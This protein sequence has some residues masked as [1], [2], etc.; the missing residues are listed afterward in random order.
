MET[1]FAHVNRRS[2][3]TRAATLLAAGSSLAAPPLQADP[4]AELASFSVFDKADLAQLRGDARAVRGAPMN[5][6]RFLSVQT[7]WVAPGTPAQQLQALRQW[8][9]SRHSELRVHLHSGGSNFSRLAQAP[10]NAA[11]QWLVTATTSKSPDLQLSRAEAAKLPANG[12]GMS[13]PVA[14]FWVGV[15]SARSSIGPTGQPPYEHGGPTIKPGAEINGMLSQQGKIQ[16]QFSGLL[17]GRGDQFWELLEV[18]N[19]GVL[20]LGTSYQRS[21][22]GGTQQAGDVLYYASGGFYAA[23]TLHQMWPVQVEGKPATLIWRG[24]M[25]S[26]ASVGDLRGVERMGSESVMMRDISRAVR[27]FR[28]DSAGIR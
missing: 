14:D 7:V 2:F 19:K 23:I 1:N 12:S 27:L 20:V 8:N 21:G 18:E 16:K 24:D 4:V 25:T 6:P 22:A 13:G 5:T 10:N 17:G 11:V 9:P 15:L 3:F 26:S 28:R